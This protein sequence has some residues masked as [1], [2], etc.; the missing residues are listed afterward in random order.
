[1]HFLLIKSGFKFSNVH[2]TTNLLSTVYWLFVIEGAYVSFGIH[3]A[4]GID[5]IYIILDPLVI[6]EPGDTG[7]HLSD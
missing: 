7:I 6:Q 3:T 1:M 5:I 4:D 2:L